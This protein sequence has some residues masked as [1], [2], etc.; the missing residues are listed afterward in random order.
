MRIS[1]H[2]TM[3]NVN[4]VLHVCL[5]QTNDCYLHKT[6][7]VVRE[8]AHT[9]THPRSIPMTRS[10]MNILRDVAQFS[11]W[12][13]HK[14]KD[15][16]I[17]VWENYRKRPMTRRTVL[18]W[19]SLTIVLKTSRSCDEVFGEYTLN[20]FVQHHRYAGKN[21][22]YCQMSIDAVSSH[23]RSM[24]TRKRSHKYNRS[25]AIG[26][27]RKIWTSRSSSRI[28]MFLYEVSYDLND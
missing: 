9:L 22:I 13:S 26:L 24:S 28:A 4:V 25:S 27:S 20:F 8:R 1:Q 14:V 17:Q 6:H 23:R 2:A 11:M 12:H 18:R 7:P 5:F 3:K 10:M 19:I 15:C 21:Q 16:C